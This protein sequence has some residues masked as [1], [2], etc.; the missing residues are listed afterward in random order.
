MSILLLIG[1]I[2]SFEAYSQ[3]RLTKSQR[4]NYNGAAWMNMLEDDKWLGFAK[5]YK[6][7]KFIY[8]EIM[9]DK[10]TAKLNLFAVSNGL[11]TNGGY[12]A[13]VNKKTL[14]KV[15]EKLT[16][17]I[18]NCVFDKDSLYIFSTKQTWEAASK[19]NNQNKSHYIDNV[20]IVAPQ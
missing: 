3:T 14:S 6:R 13:R 20:Y 12:L 4:L 9:P 10:N 17:S 19:C 5:K 2:D 15:K 16:I 11:I 7:I 1:F 18:E 8:P